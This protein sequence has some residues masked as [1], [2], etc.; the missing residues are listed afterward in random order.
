MILKQTV[1]KVWDMFCLDFVPDVYYE[2]LP[3]FNNQINDWKSKI[4]RRYN[5]G[6]VIS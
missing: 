6:N 5:F 1:L 3:P 2:D 4:H